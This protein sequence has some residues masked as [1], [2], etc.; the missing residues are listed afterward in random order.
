ME[1]QKCCEG[2]LMALFSAVSCSIKEGTGTCIHGKNEC[3]EGHYP[4]ATVEI[5]ATKIV[6]GNALFPLS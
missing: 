5:G 2:D 3:L 6:R 4:H 1:L